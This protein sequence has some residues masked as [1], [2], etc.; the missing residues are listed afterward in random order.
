MENIKLSDVTRAL[1]VEGYHVSIAYQSMSGCLFTSAE[2]IAYQEKVQNKKNIVFTLLTLATNE[3]QVQLDFNSTIDNKKSFFT[4]VTGAFS[5]VSFVQKRIKSSILSLFISYIEVYLIKNY[6]AEQLAIKLPPEA[7]AYENT[8]LVTNA[9]FT[10]NWRIEELDLNYHFDVVSESEFKSNLSSSKRRELNRITREETV[11]SKAET[12]YDIISA[13]EIIKSNRLSQG[14]P[15]TMSQDALLDLYKTLP[16]KVHFF[17]LKHAGNIL[18][19]AVCLTVNP[20][21]LY[22]FYWGENPQYR[23]LSPVIKLAQELYSFA[24]KAGYK[25]MD[26]GIS[27]ENSIPNQGLMDFKKNIGCRLTK[28][29]TL[30]KKIG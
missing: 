28:K 9:L 26:I 20:D 16:G 15:M 24:M 27:T 6:E 10:Q 14:Y 22:V 18:A 8:N 1:E 23:D 12:E 2:F 17:N 21:Y 3:A 19:S 25:K 30:I 11:F 7:Y 13:Y 4:P 29:I 5:D